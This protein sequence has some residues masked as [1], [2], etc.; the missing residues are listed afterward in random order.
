[1]NNQC[2]LD[3]E[4]LLVDSADLVE[5]DRVTLAHLSELELMLVGGGLANV[6]FS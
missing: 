6:T 3:L 1:M 5:E 2:E 4:R